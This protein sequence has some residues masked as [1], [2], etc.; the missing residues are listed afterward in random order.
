[1]KKATAENIRALD[2]TPRAD[3]V[4]TGNI[5]RT[6][7]AGRVFVDFPGNTGGPVMAKITGSAKDRLREEG[8]SGHPGVLLVFENNDPR[9][10][11]IIDTLHPAIGEAEPA[12]SVTL[13]AERP[14][15]VT[16]DGKRVI[17]DAEEEIV[18]R[19]GK[20]SITLTRAGK[21]IIRGAYLLN[22]SS[23]VNRIKGASVQIN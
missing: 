14:E 5:I 2:V 8:V 18:L 21:I 11:V 22:R 20:A 19:C 10:P 15:A 3:G 23:G 16:V 4:R 7:E 1:M 12:E 9:R 6:D 17:F 13:P